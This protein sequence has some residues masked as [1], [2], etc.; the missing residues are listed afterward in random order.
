[1][2][3]IEARQ[4]SKSYWLQGS[5]PQTLMGRLTHSLRR[6]Q[7]KLVWA[8]KDVSFGI[9]PGETVGIIGPNGSGKSS[10][11]GLIAG[12][13]APT[14][15]TV[16]SRGRICS[17]LELGAG[18]HSELTGRENIFLN[19]AILGIPRATIARRFE[20][21]VDF[22][23]IRE[24]LDMPVK[25]YSSGMY[26]R[27]GFSIAVEMDPD[28]L[29]IDEV[30]AVGDAA[31]QAKCL[32]RIR[33]FQRRGKTLVIVSHA[34]ETI[35]KFCQRALLFY[36]GRLVAEGTPPDVILSYLKSYMGEGGLVHTMEYGNREAEI[37]G[38]R[39]LN[40]AGQEQGTFATGQPLSVEI[41]YR[42]TK[43]IEKPV[44]GFAIKTGNGIYVFGSNTQIAGWQI[45]AIEGQGN[46]RLHI[47][48][49]P[50]MEG[51][52]FLSL[53][54]HS[55]DHAIQYHRRDDWYP[56]VVTNPSGTQGLFQL[57]VH[58]EGP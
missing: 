48:P 3:A 20:A 55:W 33:D 24:Y 19:G 44:F 31:F 51:N 57:P 50:L 34:L 7:R 8:L 41:S 43:R 4:L 53:A 27:L 28:I 32:T 29:L 30:L 38:A 9:R 35:E 39:F 52:F 25:F 2:Y 47:D 18:F 40:A 14:T 36:Q 12:T 42:T 1:M 23:G 58:W 54:I 5:E 49:L 21:I 26:V 13:T 45:P 22:A 56:F 37:T 11:L 17:L 6:R 10:T 16:T 46:L 15:G